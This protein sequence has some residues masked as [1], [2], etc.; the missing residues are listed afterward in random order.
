MHI[1]CNFIKVQ[2]K[3]V[4]KYYFSLHS[5]FKCCPFYIL[6]S[7]HNPILDVFTYLFISIFSSLTD[8]RSCPHEQQ[9]EEILP[10]FPHCVTHCCLHAFTWR[11]GSYNFMWSLSHPGNLDR[12]Y[13]CN[14][15]GT[16]LSPSVF[17]SMDEMSTLEVVIFALFGF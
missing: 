16:A 11:A 6:E 7:C 17:L 8:R 4:I 9:M 12:I 10:A 1:F 15:C 3:R 13:I 5:D 14:P 2:T